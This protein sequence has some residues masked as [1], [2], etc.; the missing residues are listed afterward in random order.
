MVLGL[1][2]LAEVAALLEKVSD[3]TA[4]LEVVH[5]AGWLH[6][7]RYLMFG[8]GDDQHAPSTVPCLSAP[9]YR[10]RPDASPTR[11][12]TTSTLTSSPRPAITR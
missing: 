10:A 11:S 8:P 6:L 5:A 9:V 7:G 2:T 3:L 1:T 4:D 12:V